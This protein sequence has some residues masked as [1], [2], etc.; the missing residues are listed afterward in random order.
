MD[1]YHYDDEGNFILDEYGYPIPAYICICAAHSTF[2][3]C[4]GAWE[5]EIPSDAYFN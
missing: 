3:C 1:D 2:E 5:K 4:C